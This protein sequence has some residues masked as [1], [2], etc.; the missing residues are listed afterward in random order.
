MTT[1]TKTWKRGDKVECN[2]NKEAVVLDPYGDGMYTVRLWDG[3]RHVGDVCV[4][5]SE[6]IARDDF[7]KMPN[8]SADMAAAEV[9]SKWLSDTGTV[10]VVAERLPNNRVNVYRE[11]RPEY[12]V[13]VWHVSSLTRTTVRK[14]AAPTAILTPLTDDEA[15]LLYTVQRCG[16][17]GY[18]IRKLAPSKWIIDAW[19]SWTGFP[20]V[21][22]TKKAA[23]AQFE[24]WVRAAL[25]RWADMK[26]V[27]PELILTAVGVKS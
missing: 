5:G 11:D 1:A 4:G 13:Y 18:P 14:M 26:R 17:D 24:S 7:E 12:R 15:A 27:N 9:G 22:K 6:L 10:W 21:Y 8:Y 19:R 3:L 16:S 20:V 2:G 25:D 23:V